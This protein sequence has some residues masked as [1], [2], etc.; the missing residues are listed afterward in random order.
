MN[1]Q[2]SQALA[3]FIGSASTVL[4]WIGAYY[5]GPGKK[6]DRDD[7]RTRRSRRSRGATDR[8]RWDDPDYDGP[9]R[10]RSRERYYHAED[11]DE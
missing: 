1:D 4:L 3:L 6:Q 9:E 5:W 10:R 7:D 8:R 2:L 11:E